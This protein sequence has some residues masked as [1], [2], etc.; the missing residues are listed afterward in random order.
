MIIEIKTILMPI[1]AASPLIYTF[2]R[3]LKRKKKLESLGDVELV[4]KPKSPLTKRM[5]V[6][7]GIIAALYFIINFSLAYSHERLDIAR[8]IGSHTILLAS[9]AFMIY[10]Y[11]K[12]FVGEKGI[13]G[14]TKEVFLWDTIE[15]VEFDNDIKQTQ[16]G[17]KFYMIDQK[18]PLKF[19]FKRSKIEELKKIFEKMKKI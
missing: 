9:L 6:I 14:I 11:G 5:S 8:I 18:T 4:V 16:Y 2:F 19:Y 1:V 17:V 13:Y 7:I 12:I 15:K 3:H 10:D